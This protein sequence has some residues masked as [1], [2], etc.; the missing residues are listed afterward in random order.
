[1]GGRICGERFLLEKV[2]YNGVSVKVFNLEDGFI[3]SL[4]R[5]D[6][7]SDSLFIYG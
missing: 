3:I 5:V 4:I 1:M 2:V 6:V 7:L